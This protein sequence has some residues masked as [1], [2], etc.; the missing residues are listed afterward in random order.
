[1]GLCA[2]K[3]MLGVVSVLHSPAFEDEQRNAISSCGIVGI[4]IHQV[5]GL[6]G[7]DVMLEVTDLTSRPRMVELSA[8][9]M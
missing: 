3:G 8:C 6:R 5:F 4:G 1:M 2:F 7:V 9:S